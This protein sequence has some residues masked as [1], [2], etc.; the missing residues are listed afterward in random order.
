[1]IDFYYFWKCNNL[2]SMFVLELIAVP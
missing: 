1:M 2:D